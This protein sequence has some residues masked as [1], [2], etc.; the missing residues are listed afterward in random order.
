MDIVK[1]LRKASKLFSPEEH[2]A[3]DE[4][5]QLRKS[6][7]RC[8]EEAEGWLDDA[9]GCKPADVMNYDGWADEARRLLGHNACDNR[10]PRSGD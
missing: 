1:R 4:I 10:T 3:A 6:L 5:D 7:A 2:E 9:R 8:L